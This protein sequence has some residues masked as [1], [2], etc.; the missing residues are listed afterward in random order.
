MSF[1]DDALDAGL[2]AVGQSLA[3]SAS[4]YVQGVT[5]PAVGGILGSL[6]AGQASGGANLDRLLADARI[7]SPVTA[8]ILIS[9]RAS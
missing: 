6:F 3:Q 4:G 5:G 9:S 7:D 1:F 2:G 8:R